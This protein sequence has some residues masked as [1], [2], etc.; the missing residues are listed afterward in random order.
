MTVKIIKA[1]SLVGFVCCFGKAWAS[2]PMEPYAVKGKI[3]EY[4]TGIGLQG[5]K[6]FVFLDHPKL[7][8]REWAG[9]GQYPD[10]AI[11]ADDGSFEA[12]ST[13]QSNR[14]S[15]FRMHDCRA[16]P[17]QVVVFVIAPE[18]LARRKIFDWKKLSVETVEGPYPAFSI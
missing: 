4:R 13:L 16:R 8:E 10:W 17:K 6:V 2:C 11:S 15:F 5:S 18:Y 1:F 14:L 9:S 3:V 7:G 12:H